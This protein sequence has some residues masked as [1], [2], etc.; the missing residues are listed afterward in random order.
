MKRFAAILFV[1]LL[2]V[3]CE[4][5]RAGTSSA[6]APA[7]NTSP[8]QPP[9][10]KLPPAI[11][12][13]DFDESPLGEYTTTTFEKDWPSA[14][15][16][17]GLDSSRAEIVEGAASY[18]GRSLRL[19]YPAQTFGPGRQA[20]QAWINL[21][22]RYDELFLSYRILFDKDF[23]WM[24]GGKLP[25]LLGGEGNTGGD[26]PDGSDGW[27][28]RMMW[29]EGGSAVQYVYHPDQPRHWGQD[30]PWNRNFQQGRWHTVEHRIVMNTPGER[31][32]IIQGW[33][34][35][36][37]VLD[38]KTLRFRDQSNFSIDALYISTFFGGDN[39]TWAPVRDNYVYFDDF[40]IAA[41]R[42]NQ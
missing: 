31:N 33:F 37:L 34:D 8:D 2:L 24:R 29:R 1:V 21:P 10:K 18:A 9:A 39:N 28:A 16:A 22:K 15:W 25:G 32:G 27:S 19:K 41:S 36:R 40:Y 11:L 13:V 20:I 42:I 30:F 26:K 3:G 4:G 38:L 23:E 35:G 7:A 6:P 14:E 5:K 17:E 12:K